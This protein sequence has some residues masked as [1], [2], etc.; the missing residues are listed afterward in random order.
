MFA[1]AIWDRARRRLFLARDRIGIKPLYYWWDGRRLAFASEI[2]ALLC[3]PAIKAEPNGTAIAEYWRAMYTSGD[4]TWFNRHR[5][6]GLRPVV[7]QERPDQRQGLRVRGG[8]RRGRSS[9]ASPK[10]R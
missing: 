1:F 3:H 6:A 4:Q 7:R 10:T 9:S 5:L 2:K 8:V